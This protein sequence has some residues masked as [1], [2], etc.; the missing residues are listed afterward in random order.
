M[1]SVRYLYTAH[2]PR[3]HD[4]GLERCIEEKT[5]RDPLECCGVQKHNCIHYNK[6]IEACVDCCADIVL[7][8]AFEDAEAT[9]VLILVVLAKKPRGA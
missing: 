2:R 8:P 1:A 4:M 6:R 5:K 7:D 9:A 3:H